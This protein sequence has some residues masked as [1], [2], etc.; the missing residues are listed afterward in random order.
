MYLYLFS[1][2]PCV[3]PQECWPILRLVVSE[4][5]VTCEIT[6]IAFSVPRVKYKTIITTTHVRP[7]NKTAIS[8]YV[9]GRLLQFSR[10][11]GK[12]YSCYYWNDHYDLTPY[13]NGQCWKARHRNHLTAVSPYWTDPYRECPVRVVPRAHGDRAS[14]ISRCKTVKL[15]HVTICAVVQF[16]RA[17]DR[18]SLLSNIGH[19]YCY[20]GLTNIRLNANDF[21]VTNV[22][23]P[24]DYDIH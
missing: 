19:H 14:C 10:L 11:E 21:I 24:T 15:N 9:D 18:T 12:P 3:T 6:S 7:K 23:P 8:G 20:L 13:C 16:A 1:P 4:W 22:H 2:W 5:I 17:G